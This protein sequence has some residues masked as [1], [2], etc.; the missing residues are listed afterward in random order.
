MCECLADCA[1]TFVL[2]TGCLIFAIVGF[3]VLSID[4]ADLYS[5][6]ATLVVIV[7]ILSLLIYQIV[8]LAGQ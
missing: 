4:N 8:V 3:I 7:A 6:I 2:L 5:Y 1:L